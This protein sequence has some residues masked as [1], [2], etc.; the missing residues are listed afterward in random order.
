MNIK[1]MIIIT[2]INEHCLTAWF[3]FIVAVIVR[4][5]LGGLTKRLNVSKCMS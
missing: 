4:L 1:M 5:K 2:L 3:L